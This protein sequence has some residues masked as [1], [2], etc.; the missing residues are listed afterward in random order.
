MLP[1]D[2]Q[3]VE[4]QVAGE[5]DPELRGGEVLPQRL[6]HG[7]ALL[8]PGIDV[9]DRQDEGVAAHVAR[10]T[11]DILPE[12]PLEVVRGGRVGEPLI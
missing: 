2:Q 11:V 6:K 8:E 7:P 12:A 10:R 9:V 5:N 1:T 3:G 4:V